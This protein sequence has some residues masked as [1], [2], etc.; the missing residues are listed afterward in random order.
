MIPGLIAGMNSAAHIGGCGGCAETKTSN[1]AMK[2]MKYL[3]QPLLALSMA[4]ALPLLSLAEDKATCPA[5]AAKSD[6]CCPSKKAAVCP[7]SG[8][9]TQLTPSAQGL[10]HA[11]FKVEGM[12]CAA[13]ETK[14]TKA[15]NAIEGVKQASACAESKLAKVSYNPEKAKDRDL[16][17]AIRQAGFKVQAETVALKV[18]GMSCTACSDK[19]AKKLAAL[20]GVSEQK[21]CHKAKQAT[22][23]FDPEKVSTKDILAA[24][25]ATGFKVVQ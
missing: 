17:A 14:V 20:K 10:I 18:D 25:N 1:V 4:A 12:S 21:V 24:I 13:C 19:V 3:F 22:V 2:S 23:T 8:A 5:T 7:V 9:T 6:A 15:L 11:Q 16:A